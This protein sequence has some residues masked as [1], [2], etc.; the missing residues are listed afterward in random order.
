[1]IK[2]IK[3]GKKEAWREN[4]Q[5]QITM[6]PNS[7]MDVVVDWEDH[8]LEAGKYR[9]E[10]E[11]THPSNVW[12]WEETFVVEKLEARQI[13]SHAIELKQTRNVISYVVT[14]GMTL[15]VV[16]VGLLFYIRKLKK[17]VEYI[18]KTN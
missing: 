6:A 4:I 12:N 7:S 10:V 13:N 18:F 2:Y 5:D 15:L 1:M 16:I 14:G 8:P 11:A 3:D 9:V 17:L